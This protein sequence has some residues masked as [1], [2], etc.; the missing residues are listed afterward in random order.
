MHIAYV[1]MFLSSILD[2]VIEIF[3]GHD[4]SGHTMAPGL[5]L[6]L[7]DMSTRNISWVVKVAGADLTTF[8]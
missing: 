5:T 8:M 4:P 1:L 6:P 2:N 7:T 3:H